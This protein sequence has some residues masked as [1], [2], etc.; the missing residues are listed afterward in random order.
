MSLKEVTGSLDIEITLDELFK[1]SEVS[2]A[3]K[4]VEFDN[5][6]DEMLENSVD[7]YPTVILI[8]FKSILRLNFP[9][10]SE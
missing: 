3:G 10:D 1:G 6:F 8:S 2:K 4:A 9:F 5:T 7:V